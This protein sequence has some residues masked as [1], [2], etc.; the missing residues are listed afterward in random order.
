[1]CHVVR[2]QRSS[3]LTRHK[4]THTGERPFTCGGCG[5]SFARSDKLRVHTKI[6][7]RVRHHYKRLYSF[8]S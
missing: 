1:M 4:L 8:S 7:E 3:H 5:R 2:F 6:C